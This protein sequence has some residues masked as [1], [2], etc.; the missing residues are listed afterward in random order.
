MQSNFPI[1][2]VQVGEPL[3]FEQADNVAG[4]HPADLV[5]SCSL[6]HTC[7]CTRAAR[8]RSGRPLQRRTPSARGPCRPQS[9]RPICSAWPRARWH[10]AAPASSTTRSA[11]M[12][13]QGTGM[14]RCPGRATCRVHGACLHRDGHFHGSELVFLDPSL[15]WRVLHH[16]SAFCMRMPLGL[17]LCGDGSCGCDSSIAHGWIHWTLHTHAGA[18]TTRCT[19]PGTRPTTPSASAQRPI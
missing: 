12:H 14:L 16:V 4:D 8:W 5:A 18:G 19:G 2:L 3:P 1:T 9:W 11:T 6:T 10:P 7:A 15:C 17:G 13:A